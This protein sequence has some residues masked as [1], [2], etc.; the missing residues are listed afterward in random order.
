MKKIM[1]AI[2]ALIV[3]MILFA[4]K[5]VN[6]LN[7]QTKAKANR[8]TIVKEEFKNL[9]NWVKDLDITTNQPNNN[10]ETLDIL[11]LKAQNEKVTLKEFLKTARKQLEKYN[12]D[13]IYL[14]NIGV[15]NWLSSSSWGWGVAGY[16]NNIKNKEV[17]QQ[18][19]FACF[20]LY[21]KK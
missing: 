19:L 20:V 11:I 7:S 5:G 9:E 3:I 14:K 6:N 8:E 2:T 13:L 15:E 16:Q 12:A 18:I 4:V 10:Y 17:K 21:K 1:M